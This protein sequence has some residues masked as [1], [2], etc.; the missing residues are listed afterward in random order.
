MSKHR[1]GFE[2]VLFNIL[3]NK[4]KNFQAWQKMAQKTQKTQPNIPEN[5]VSFDANPH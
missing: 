5:Y 2:R 3:K 4:I 1:A